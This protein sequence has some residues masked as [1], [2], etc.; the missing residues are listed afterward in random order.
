MLSESLDANISQDKPCVCSFC[1]AVRTYSKEDFYP[2]AASEYNDSVMCSD[3]VI[4]LNNGYKSYYNEH[5]SSFHRFRY[6]LNHN[7]VIL[8]LI[9]GYA[10]FSL[11]RFVLR[12]I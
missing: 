4:G 9:Y 11:I 1:G 10:I 12:Y 6:F 7:P 2:W 5:V 3:C 8:T